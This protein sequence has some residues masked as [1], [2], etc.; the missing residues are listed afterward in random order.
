MISDA[1]AKINSARDIL[2]K[3]IRESEGCELKAYR[4]PAGIWTIGYGVTGERIYRGLIWTQE[5][6]ESKLLEIADLVLKSATLTSPVL[7]NGS[8]QRLAAIADFI[9]NLGIGSYRKST[10]RKKVDVED[11]KAAQTEIVKWVRGGGKVLPGLVKRRAKEAD[12]LA[13]YF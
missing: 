7:L 6:A 5:K 4:C 11:W 10:L 3:L 2:T 12:L 9:F 13:D 1:Q 8:P